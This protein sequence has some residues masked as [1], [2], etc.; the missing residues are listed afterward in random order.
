MQVGYVLENIHLDNHLF[1]VATTP[2]GRKLL[3]KRLTRGV[4]R[5]KKKTLRPGHIK[6][7]GRLHSSLGT[8]GILKMG[9]VGGGKVLVW[10]TIEDQWGGK[11]AASTY[12]DAVLP[13]LKKRFRD[14]KSFTILEDN[15]PV[16]SRSNLAS[17]AKKESKMKVLHIP[18]RSPDLNVLDFAIWSQVERLMRAQER[19]MKD[20]RES[21]AQ[22]EIR[23][24]RTAF[25]LTSKFVNCSIG[26]LQRRCQLL[27]DAKGGL[28]EEGGRSRRPL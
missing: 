20:K 9:G 19:K 1:K 8:K 4:Y 15:D 7:E 25:G 22:F 24:D 6:P 16:G 2:A 26:N 5:Q 18:K 23:L 28:F 3:A 21:R 14:V 12:K 17:A 11:V 10:E 13:A 27:Y